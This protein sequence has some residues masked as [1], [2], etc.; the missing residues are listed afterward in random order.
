MRRGIKSPAQQL[1]PA[2]IGTA[3]QENPVAKFTPTSF[4]VSLTQEEVWIL[5][6]AL[7]ILW[8]YS[9]E[10]RLFSSESPDALSIDSL[11]TLIKEFKQATKAS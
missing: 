4:Q 10:S 8:S 6:E 2:E 11:E 9:E 5:E 7:K 1:P 3:Q